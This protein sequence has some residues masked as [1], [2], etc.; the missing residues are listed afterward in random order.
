M[1][2]RRTGWIALGVASVMS[3]GTDVYVHEPRETQEAAERQLG[4]PFA[5]FLAQWGNAVANVTDNCGLTG[6]DV[7]V[8]AGTYPAPTNGVF[9]A[10]EPR[11]LPNGP[12]PDDVMVL[13]KRGFTVGYSPSLH[14][15]VWVAYRTFPT[16]HELTLPRPA[17]KSDPE[18]PR[19]P[20]GE[21]YSKSGYD[22]GHLA[23]NLAIATRFGAAGQRETFLTS[24]I[25][26][27]RPSL[28]RGPWYELEYRIAEIWPEEYRN[29][30][31]L[32]GS[33]PSVNHETLRGGVE[34]PAGFF[35]I[36]ATE[37]KG[38]IRALAVYMPQTSRY[39]DYARAKLVT[40]DEIERLTGFDFL[41]DLPDEIEN[42][43]EAGLPTRLWPAGFT[44]LARILYERY[45][46]YD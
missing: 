40:I 27:Q 11:R 38:R 19:S 45:R 18:A 7:V 22:R 17:F 35:Q 10:G 30:W 6:H 15:P 8:P 36:V 24:N 3:I 25:C 16:S 31:V 1:L 39:A 5:Q 41:A 28:N 29:V 37:S 26:P 44:G 34:V 42:A 4:R 13:K 21:A 2:R 12:A 9:F 33:V 32:V 23:P 46:V 14:H 43:L 20:R